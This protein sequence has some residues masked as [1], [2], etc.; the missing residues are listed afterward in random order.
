[1]KKIFAAA[2]FAAVL[3]S[4]TACNNGAGSSESSSG[5]SSSTLSSSTSSS[6]STSTSSSTGSST[7]STNSTTSITSTSTE[8]TSSIGSGS[9]DSSVVSESA[10]DSVPESLE[11]ESSE[12]Q[13]MEQSTVSVHE[14]Q[15]AEE[16]I[17]PDCTEDGYT[18]YT[19]SCG[20]Q[21]TDDIVWAPGHDY[22]QSVVNA[23]CTD[24]GYTVNTCVRCGSEFISDRTNAAGH[25]WG[26]WVTVTAATASAEGEEISECRVCGESQRRSVPKL[27]DFGSYASEVVNIVNAER[28]KE[29][30]PALSESG[31]LSQYAMLRSS[32]LVDNFAHKRPDGSSP[33][34]YVMGLSGVYTSGENIAMGQTSPENVMNDW[35]NS[36]GHHANIMNPDF[37]MIGVGCYE[38]NGR[39]YWT[40]IFAG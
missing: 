16:I 35:M 31:E 37:T 38:Y 20:S 11:D 34:S 9:S 27:K 7:S 17:S 12:V 28:A 23:T 18:I 19:C 32:E 30:L 36:A 15:Y 29:G 6:A 8:S 4:V 10:V 40:Q 25:S 22:T 14:H 13:P 5:E 24:G 39:L 1:M 33:L 26:D 3:L 2:V 21:Y